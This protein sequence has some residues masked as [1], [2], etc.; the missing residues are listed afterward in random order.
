M[1]RTE[2]KPDD[3]K[4]ARTISMTNNEWGHLKR[5]ATNAGKEI[6][7]FVIEKLKIKNEPVKES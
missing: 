2:K 7:Q 6:S 1:G 5:L 3:R 4:K